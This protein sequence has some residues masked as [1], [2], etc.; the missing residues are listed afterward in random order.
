MVSK[1]LIGVWVALDVLL[2]AAGVVALILSIV[3]RAP[4]ILMN[5]VLSSADLTGVSHFAYSF[6]S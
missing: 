3:W 4:N 5:M 2:L 1:A 6:S